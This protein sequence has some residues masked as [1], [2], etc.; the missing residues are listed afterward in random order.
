MSPIMKNKHYINVFI[1]A[2]CIVANSIRLSKHEKKPII[3]VN[4]P[5]DIRLS[6]LVMSQMY[7][8]IFIE[9]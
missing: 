3:N 7:C 4:K 9:R 6:K 5:Q 8:Q 1:N 2:Y